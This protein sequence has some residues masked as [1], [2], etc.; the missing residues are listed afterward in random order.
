MDGCI[1]SLS[2]NDLYEN[3][4]TLHSRTTQ[5]SKIS[6]PIFNKVIRTY[7]QEVDHEWLY[8][9]IRHAPLVQKRPLDRQNWSKRSASVD[10]CIN[11]LVPKILFFRIVPNFQHIFDYPSVSISDF[12]YLEKHAWLLIKE[13]WRVRH[14]GHFPCQLIFLPREIRFKGRF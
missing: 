7:L 13:V 1:F 8:I 4:P 6:T 9:R 3:D 10:W 14:T 5:I 12:L 2:I 11:P